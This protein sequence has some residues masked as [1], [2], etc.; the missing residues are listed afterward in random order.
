LVRTSISIFNFL[1]LSFLSRA[2]KSISSDIS[3]ARKFRIF[4]LSFSFLSCASSN[5]IFKALSLVFDSAVS[6]IQFS[7]ICSLCFFATTKS[8]SAA[9]HSAGVAA[10]SF[11]IILGTGFMKRP[12]GAEAVTAMF[13]DTIRIHYYH[14]VRITHLFNTEF[15]FH[16]PLYC[17][18]RYISY[19]NVHVMFLC[20]LNIW[21]V[22]YCILIN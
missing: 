1:I 4:L 15:M 13:Y 18:I 6:W 8:C 21:Y 16:L 19:L 7:S 11:A 20:Y 3:A 22:L 14:I 2:M 5:L 9:R 12:D 10:R 17:M